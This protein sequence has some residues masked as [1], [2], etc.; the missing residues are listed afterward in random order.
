MQSTENRR[1][2]FEAVVTVGNP[3]HLST[4]G[5]KV[6]LLVWLHQRFDSQ[7]AL[8]EHCSPLLNAVSGLRLVKNTNRAMMEREVVVFS[9]DSLRR[10][11]IALARD[12]E[13]YLH[14]AATIQ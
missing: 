8:E 7:E 9:P 2:S 10:A 12:V 1:S 5:S 3:V 6:T 14:K 13:T 11:K 4:A